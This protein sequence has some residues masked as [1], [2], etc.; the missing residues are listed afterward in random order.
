MLI[1]PQNTRCRSLSNERLFARKIISV[2]VLK[3]NMYREVVAIHDFMA[4]QQ[5]LRDAVFFKCGKIG[6]AFVVL[7]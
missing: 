3:A 1:T 4:A 5:G 2:P 6:Y 7:P